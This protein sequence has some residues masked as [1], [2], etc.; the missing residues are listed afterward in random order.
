MKYK[1][2]YDAVRHGDWGPNGNTILI[3]KTI[4]QQPTGEKKYFAPHSKACN[5]TWLI[6]QVKVKIKWLTH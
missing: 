4:S 5:K 2:L 1:K 3:K 6:A